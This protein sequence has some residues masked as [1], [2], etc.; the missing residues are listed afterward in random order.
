MDE[1]SQDAIE[2][3][4]KYRLKFEA[5][6]SVM[7][8]ESPVK[9]A[10]GIWHYMNR[11]SHTD[12]KPTKLNADKIINEIKSNFKP[13]EIDYTNYNN[14]ELPHWDIIND[15]NKEMAERTAKKK[16]ELIVNALKEHG[17]TFQNKQQLYEF[18]K[19]CEVRR[20][21]YDDK[22]EMPFFIPIT[23]LW[24]E[25]ECICF[26]D[27]KIDSEIKDNTMIIKQRFAVNPIKQAKP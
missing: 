16:E 10:Y 23:E 15:I 20:H 1:D 22:L 11:L 7:F 24:Y 13:I 17:H 6:D 27:E 25:N 5:E 12:F 18:A 19:R 4:S 8:G 26:W 3:K 2:L 9:S 21:E 14:I